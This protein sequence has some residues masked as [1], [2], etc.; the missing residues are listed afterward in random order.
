MP[1]SGNASDHCCW[2]KGKPC[3]LLIENYVDET[4]YF[5]RWACGLRAKLGNWDDV[6]VHPD[7]LAATANAWKDGL[8]CRDWPDGEGPN[9]GTC[10]DMRCRIKN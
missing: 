3:T 7:Y 8:N 9:H 10:D 2:V 1:C 5:R 6:I 4:G